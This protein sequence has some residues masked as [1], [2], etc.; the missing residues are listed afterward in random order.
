MSTSIGIQ[1]T[2]SENDIRTQ[3]NQNIRTP[4]EFSCSVVNPVI[5]EPGDQILIKSVFLNTKSQTSGNIIIDADKKLTFKW[6]A[7]HIPKLDDKVDTGNS[8]TDQ[9]IG[10]DVP[11]NL[12]GQPFIVMVRADYYNTLLKQTFANCSPTVAP[13][14]AP[15]TE[16]NYTYYT[17]ANYNQPGGWNWTDGS[18][19]PLEFQFQITIPKGSYSP[20]ALS[21]YI[22]TQLNSQPNMTCY[23][24]TSN[25]PPY[26]PADTTLSQA[27]KNITY[28]PQYADIG[29]FTSIFPDEPPTNLV[30]SW[31]ENP[32]SNSPFLY[33]LMDITN[34]EFVNAWN[35]TPL[36]GIPTPEDPNPPD[37][38]GNH[39]T[40]I[41]LFKHLYSDA[42]FHNTNNSLFCG[43][44]QIELLF[45]DINSGLFSWINHSPIS[46]AGQIS[47]EYR[48][49]KVPYKPD[50]GE[51]IYSPFTYLFTKQSGIMWTYLDPF[52]EQLGFDDSIYVKYDDP[53]GPY[54]M[55]PSTFRNI[56]SDT[57]C[58]LS[59]INSDNSLIMTG[60]P[61]IFGD[62][63]STLFF[64]SADFVELYGRYPYLASLSD[65]GHYLI[66]LNAYNSKIQTNTALTNVKFIVPT[67]YVSSGGSY[68]YANQIS[69]FPSIY[70]HLAQPFLFGYCKVRVLNPDLTPALLSTGNFL[71]IEVISNKNK[72]PNVL[73]PIAEN[74]DKK[75]DEQQTVY[76]AQK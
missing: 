45:N 2:D 34:W 53:S 63:G 14:A 9:Y 5:V 73:K 65:D 13:I 75:H 6:V 37:I 19:V 38:T 48:A 27:W 11:A 41:Y 12:I 42:Y 51:Y 54:R 40:Y 62:S 30:T 21:E 32:R 18:F 59:Q 16:I 76:A 1:L 57:F 71:Y 67:Y 22:T 64:Q 8:D 20:G 33:N 25:V 60:K 15:Y 23:N 46:N 50:G 56:T 39:K 74:Q 28:T 68:I 24:G 44:N 36:P 70:T 31:L 7:Y 17:D 43:T 58:S 35:N 10:K 72:S 52:F 49:F 69:S 47:V 61:T 66:E 26:I 3:R 55:Y 29:E 4:C